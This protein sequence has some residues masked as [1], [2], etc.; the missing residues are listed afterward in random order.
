V[1]GGSSVTIS[2]ASSGCAEVATW[3]L[4]RMSAD[5]E[6]DDYINTAP[7]TLAYAI[8]G[9][10]TID[11]VEYPT[12]I[13]HDPTSSTGGWFIGGPGWTTGFTN[14]IP[15]VCTPDSG[16]QQYY[17]IGTASQDSF[18]FVPSDGNNCTM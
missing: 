6:T 16:G 11:G 3:F 18:T 15:N 14:G 4:D 13:G 8:T 1:T 2:G 17:L 12:T 7:S 10:L 5:Q 9:T